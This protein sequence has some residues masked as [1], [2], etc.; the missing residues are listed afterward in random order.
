MPTHHTL[1]HLAAAD[2]VAARAGVA[3]T[4]LK[5]EAPPRPELGDLAV[6]CFAIA[7]ARK[8]NP[9]QVAQE[10]AASIA[11]GGMIASASA[12]GPFVNFKLD[13][14]ATF[15]WV[16][17]AALRGTLIPRE[18]G[19]GKTICIDYSSPNISKHLA[20]HH[21]R[22]TTIG[23]ALAQISR[24]LGYR[25]VGINFLGDWGATHGMVIAA[26]EKWGADEPLDVTKLNDLYV[27]FR[28]AAKDNPYVEQEGRNAFKRLEDGDPKTRELWQRFRDI[29]WAEF[30]DIY[31]LL[32]IEFDEVRGESAYEAD[33]PRVFDELRP[34]LTESEGAQVVSLEGEKTPILLKTKD[35]TTLYATRDVAAAEYRWAN[36]Q[37]TRSLYVVDRG[38]AL[39]FRQLFKLLKKA[40]HAWADRCEHVPYGL[41]RVAGKRSA[42]RLGGVVLMRDVFRIA[43]EEVRQVIAEVNP[44]LPAEVVSD[45]AIKVGIGAVVF[46][47]LATHRDKDIDF[48][49][50][51][52]IALEGDS[53]PYVQY[54]HA[55]CASIARKAGETVSSV[56]GV[57][58]GKLAHDAEWAVAKKLLELP[59][60]VVR[61]GEHS[62]PH[63]VCHYLLSLAGEFSR[64][65]TL[66]NG[67]PSLR[68]LVDDAATRRARLA[69][70]AAVQATLA[71]GLALIG[72]AA[73]DQ[74]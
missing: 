9:A 8:Q 22:G 31:R 62:E 58:F 70:V 57:D 45:V 72:I 27:R 3:A 39:H 32:G 5:V 25:V 11:P 4:E 24:A 54:S 23:H 49:L 68:V 40:G 56:D 1:V 71:S 17:D 35:G 66:G 46:A 10:L 26:Y 63:L 41:I 18:V 67:D 51:K 52:A 30:E 29:S 33:M 50:D 42:T 61:A 21:I 38:Q 28:E 55:R 43:E 13:R 15:R 6:G 16:I 20:Y 14:A 37:F 34:L 59:E 12:A 48:D 73:P 65:Y 19:A 36:Y 64:W 47:N 53:G 2:A 60:L 44:S 74:M 7:K 69:L